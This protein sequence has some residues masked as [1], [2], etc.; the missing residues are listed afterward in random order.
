MSS[1]GEVVRALIDTVDQELK[2]AVGNG[3]IEKEFRR[4]RKNIVS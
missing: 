4:Q 3:T 1:N 2:T